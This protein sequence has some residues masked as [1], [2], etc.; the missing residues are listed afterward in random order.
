[1]PDPGTIIAGAVAVERASK[2]TGLTAGGAEFFKRVGGW[3]GDTAVEALGNLR[4]RRGDNLTAVVNRAEEM[5]ATAGIE[6][7]AVPL[8]LM[9][10]FLDGASAEDEPS[11]Q[12]RWAALLAN[13]SAA[14]D[15]IPPLFP[16]ML[17]ELTP[18]AAQLLDTIGTLQEA[19]IRTGVGFSIRLKGAVDHVG[20]GT[21][22]L[23]DYFDAA[24][25]L[26]AFSLI[27]RQADLLKGMPG[28]G[29]DTAYLLT[30][31]GDAF[32]SACR[33]PARP[34]AP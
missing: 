1:M 19:G 21:D 33:A 15:R 18:A 12:E 34:P 16:R 17:A 22:L 23:L 26:E 7:R 31:L 9:A 20:G 25:I 5:R 11:M 10:P 6:A 29:A 24:M 3:L 8:R 28:I 2:A 4:A 13:T 27:A 14:P 30:D 32:L